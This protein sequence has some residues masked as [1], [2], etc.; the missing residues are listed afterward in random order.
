MKKDDI[1]IRDLQLLMEQRVPKLFDDLPL[2]FQSASYH[3][4]V[5]LVE[6]RSRKASRKIRQDASANHWSPESGGIWI[7]FEPNAAA[8]A[9]E[10]VAPSASVA[11]VEPEPPNSLM[12]SDELQTLIKSLDQAESR[13]GY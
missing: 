2:Q 13:P 3:P 8:F 12:P 4:Q 1:A 5:S 7:K 6:G 11:T 9:T 10:T